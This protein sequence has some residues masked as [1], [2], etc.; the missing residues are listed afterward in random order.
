M[1]IDNQMRDEKLEYDINRNAA[2]ISAL[3][4]GE[5]NKYEYIT[6]KEILPSNQQQITEQAKF[7]Y[8]PL[9]K[10]FEKQVKTIEDQGKKQVDPL[11][12][13]KPKE[14]TKAIEGESNNQSIAAN[15]FYDLTNKRK[16]IMN[17]LYE[18]GDMNKLSF[19]Y[20]GNTKDGSFYEYM[21][22]KELFDRIKNNQLKFDDTLKK[23]KE[24]LNQISEVKLGRKTPEQEKV[25]TYLENFYK[26]R[27]DFNFFRDYTK[28]LLD[29]KYKA[30][31]G[32]TKGTGLKILTSKQLLQRLPIALSRVKA[33]N[34]SE[35]LLNE[36]RQIVYSLYQSKEITKKVYN[37]IIKSIQLCV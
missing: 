6:G 34:N 4:S 15:I 26:S 3:S 19:K 33:S 9:G 25:I 18:S 5:I 2:E 14:Q 27:K 37:N 36:I 28:L 23:Q 1:T 31:Q 22:S 17:D 10:A 13:L 21:D 12:D 30:K 11:K 32:E 8:S 24:L 16:K 7:T 20:V 35:S 29:S